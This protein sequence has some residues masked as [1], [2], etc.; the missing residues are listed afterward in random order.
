MAMIKCK[1]CGQE[2]SDMAQACPK[3]GNP[4]DVKVKRKSPV[5]AGILNFFFLFPG[6]F[7]VGEY[8]IGIALLLIFIADISQYFIMQNSINMSLGAVDIFFSIAISIALC[9]DGINRVKKY[10]QEQLKK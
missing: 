4:T 9:S 5:L 2:I 6:Y 7:Y 8:Q 3:C 10:N 1:E